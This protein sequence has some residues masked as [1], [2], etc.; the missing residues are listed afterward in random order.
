MRTMASILGFL[1]GAISP[2]LGGSGMIK[3]D[4]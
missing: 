2:A 1:M 4:G 3:E